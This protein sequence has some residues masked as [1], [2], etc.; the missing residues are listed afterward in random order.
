MPYLHWETDRYRS[1]M[2]DVID[3][4]VDT[5]MDEGEGGE[6]NDRIDEREGQEH[7]RLEE[8]AQSRAQ[9]EQLALSTPVATIASSRQPFYTARSGKNPQISLRRIPYKFRGKTDI[10]PLHH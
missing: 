7:N 9:G 5:K 1:Q 3:G 8:Y 10:F 6:R 4:A 2:V